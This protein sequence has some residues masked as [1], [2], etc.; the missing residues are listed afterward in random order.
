MKKITAFFKKRKSLSIGLLVGVVLTTSVGF[1]GNYFEISKHLDIFA[2]VFKEVNTY[3]VDE[4]EPGVLM[5][6]AI[7]SMLESLDPYTVY[8]T[9]SEIED[10]RFQTTGQYGGIGAGIRKM[11]D[12]VVITN[13]YEG[14][15][16][17]KAGL[18][19]GDVIIEIDGKST[20][21]KTSDDI[22][23]ALK[24]AAG[25]EV[26]LKVKRDGD[27]VLEKTIVREDIQVKSVP[28]Y[29]MIDEHIGY[30]VLT[31][32][33]DKASRDIK[34]A[35]KILKDEND[36]KGLVFDLRG[37]PGGLLREAVNVCNIFVD[38]G[39]EVVSTKGKVKEWDKLYKTLNNPIDTDIPLAV[40]INGGSASAS[41]IVAGT[42]QDLDRAVIVGDKSFGKGLVQQ[43]RDLTY[44]AKLKVTIAKY[45][46]PSGRCIQALDYSHRNTDGSVAKIPDSLKT[47]FKTENGRSVFDGA[48][49][50]PDVKLEA[51]EY[52][53][54]LV[55]LVTRS[56]IFD[57]ATQYQ[58][59]N[60]QLASAKDFR[61]TDKLYNDF[62]KFLADKE[63]SYDTE[64]EKILASLEETAKQEKYYEDMK[65]ELL[66][67]SKN[68]SA[69][70]K[71]DLLKHK[72][73]IKI[74]LREEIV[75]RYYYDKGRIQ[76]SLV[77]D[78]VVLKAIE[79]L[80]DKEG[81]NNIL[82]VK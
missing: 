13:P 38:K 62:V 1:T 63:Y 53:D 36:L 52:S 70:K 34:E 50:D 35:F 42:F 7:D 25:S 15:A 69:N 66:K 31:S 21:G 11:K 51:D 68:F 12:M 74:F 2:T 59:E 75:S 61:V 58:R 72:E 39:Q 78:P 67:L 23:K 76:S 29:G 48:G 17:D 32:F 73:E 10:Y 30:I 54:I 65:E 9:E 20:E 3:Y 77:D 14:F 18:K 82:A 16:A 6:K 37:N 81:Y 47:E 40:L 60:P 79:L 41:E 57:F 44:G 28:Y 55:T 56:L 49:V 4:T 27:E 22:S 64:T 46:T 80:K 5:D 45:Y 33:T 19:A 24:G 43:T 71:E 26:I 8:I